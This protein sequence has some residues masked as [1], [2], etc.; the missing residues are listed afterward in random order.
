MRGTIKFSLPFIEVGA[1]CRRVLNAS[2]HIEGSMQYNTITKAYKEDIKLPK[3]LREIM[4]LTTETFHY[5]KTSKGPSRKLFVE[6]DQLGKVFCANRVSFAFLLFFI[7][8]S[9]MDFVR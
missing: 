4:Y 6:P 7:R 3:D 2:V 9:L 1:Q 5:I 8:S